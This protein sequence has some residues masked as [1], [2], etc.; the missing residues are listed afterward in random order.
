MLCCKLLRKL[1]FLGA[2]AVA[3]P[4]VAEEPVTAPRAVPSA[5]ELLRRLEAADKRLEA[6]ETRIKSLEADLK[7]V[8]TIEDQS[9]PAAG[10]A[11]GDKK[12]PTIADVDARLK[13]FE[14]S[15]KKKADDASKRPSVRVFGRIDLDTHHWPTADP[16][17]DELETGGPDPAQSRYQVRRARIGV[18]GTIFPNV[19]YKIEMEFA[20]AVSEFR[21]LYIGLTNLPWNHTILVGN[22]KRPLGLEVM[23]SGN[24]LTFIER[25]MAGDTFNEDFRRPGISAYGYTDSEAVGWQFGVYSLND[26]KTTGTFAGNSPQLSVNGRLFASPWYDE[27]SGGRG[28][29]HVGIAGQVSDPYE[30]PIPDAPGVANTTLFRTR[31]EMRSFRRWLDTG[32]LDDVYSHNIVGAEAAFACGSFHAGG[33]YFWCNAERPEANTALTF[34]GGYV[35]AGYFLTGEHRP[36]NRQRGTWDRIKP[37]QNFFLVEQC[38][39]SIARG[40]GAW[41]VAAR[42]SYCDLTDTNVVD[43]VFGGVGRNVT[44]GL[45][46]HLNPYTKV[47][48]NYVIGH[49]DQRT[50]EDLSGDFTGFATRLH[51]DW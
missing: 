31:M 14:D 30:D 7:S 5:E 38:D 36:Y 19:I 4:L 29:F 26:F 1:V 9:L 48:F 12:A 3:T 42:Y 49:I 24:Y 50:D 11:T 35:Y 39:D 2:M 16:L 37:H 46:W 15:E 43:P 34:G 20:N 18:D 10:A 23:T 44:F 6:A 13:K 21:D 25:S 33:E 45:N 27:A 51:I 17:I 22:Q 41:E 28:Y 8:P 40:W 32:A 47:Q